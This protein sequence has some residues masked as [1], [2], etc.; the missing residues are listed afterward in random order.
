MQRP[1]FLCFA[2][3]FSAS[4]TALGQQTTYRVLY[5]NHTPDTATFNVDGSYRCS[6]TGGSKC[7]SYESGGSH[8][9]SAITSAGVKF[10]QQATIDHDGEKWCLY[11]TNDPQ[12]MADCQ[13][14]IASTGE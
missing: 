14:W 3:F 2:L 4:A 5:W 12:A 1:L 7:T 8:L 13:R 9:F 10:Q 11:Y 6:P